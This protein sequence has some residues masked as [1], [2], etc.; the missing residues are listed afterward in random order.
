[1]NIQAQVF[2][3]NNVGIMENI[4]KGLTLPKWV[5]IV[6]LKIP[7]ML[8]NLSAQF[9]C[10]S[11]KVLDFNEKMLHWVSIVRGIVNKVCLLH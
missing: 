4:N 7:Q 2:C 10:P 5:L 11:P 8:Q 1:V 3:R 9:V 6:W